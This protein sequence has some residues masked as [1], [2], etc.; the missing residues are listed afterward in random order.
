MPSLPSVPASC[1]RR[2]LASLFVVLCATP[3]AVA[4]CTQTLH[5]P[6]PPGCDGAIR[7]VIAWDIDGAG[8]LQEVI[9]AGGDFE[10]IGGVAAKGVALWDPLTDAW[11]AMGG[12]VDGQVFA[13]AIDASGALLVGGLFQ[14]ASGSVVNN[15]AR[16][17]GGYWSPLGTGVD[18]TVY[19]LAA[20]P[21]GEVF[22]GGA[23][24]M[25]GSVVAKRVARFDGT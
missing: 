5:T 18:E 22:A 10:Q 14:T 7:A 25:A 21:T 2:A 15:V 16:F 3:L 6:G 19:S 20:S 4:Q 23:F 8:P 24:S 1:L 12:G 17:D 13:L 9:V 11:Y